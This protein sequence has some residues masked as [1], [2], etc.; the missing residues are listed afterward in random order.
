MS[1]SLRLPLFADEPMVINFD[2]FD[3]DGKSERR[4]LFNFLA[5]TTNNR[6]RSLKDF[7][8]SSLAKCGNDGANDVKTIIRPFNIEIFREGNT[9]WIVK[10]K[11]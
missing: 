7:F 3:F 2:S 5:V 10:E 8:L 6:V 11:E 1:A 4:V 9:E